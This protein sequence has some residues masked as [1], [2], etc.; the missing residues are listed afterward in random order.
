MTTSRSTAPSDT[1]PSPVSGPPARP[2]G[3]LGVVALAGA[4]V[5]VAGALLSLC[6]SYVRLPWCKTPG[7]GGAVPHWEA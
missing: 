1:T 7:A 5:F 6:A 2:A 4:G 3:R